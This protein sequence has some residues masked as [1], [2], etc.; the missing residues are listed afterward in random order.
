MELTLRAARGRIDVIKSW[1]KDESTSEAVWLSVA[2]QRLHHIYL[3]DVEVILEKGTYQGTELSLVGRIQA[4]D[5]S[6]LVRIKASA[7]L[8]VRV[9]TGIIVMSCGAKYFDIR[10]EENGETLASSHN[11]R[12]VSKNT[13]QNGRIRFHRSTLATLIQAAEKVDP[14]PLVYDCE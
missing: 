6:V 3:G 5:R 1:G 8:L 14:P 7:P 2:R 4:S 10:V 11:Y 9:T 13:L 12:I